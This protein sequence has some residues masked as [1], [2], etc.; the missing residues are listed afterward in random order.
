[1]LQ[2]LSAQPPKRPFPVDELIIDFGL[3]CCATV[4]LLFLAF[5][6]FAIPAR[7]AAGIL[8][9]LHLCGIFCALESLIS[10]SGM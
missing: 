10:Y 1:V 5:T 2:T 3:G 8:G 6:G 4:A 7:S 9:I